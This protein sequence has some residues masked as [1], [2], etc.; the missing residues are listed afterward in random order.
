MPGPVSTGMGD[1]VWGLIPG[2]GK[3]ISVYNQPPR[4]TQPGHSF[5]GRCNEY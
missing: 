3:S 5:M 4:T 2:V 1:R